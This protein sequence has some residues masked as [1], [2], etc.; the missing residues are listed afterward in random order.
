MNSRFRHEGA[1]NLLKK[2]KLLIAFFFA[3]LLVVSAS[4]YSQQTKLSMKFDEITIREV[5]RQIEE[6]SEFVFFY[7]EDY[8]NVNRKVCINVRD[9]K[10]E[11]ILNELFKG[12]ENSF[13][14]YD[15]QIV[16]LSPE[17]KEL[18]P[19]MRA[20]TK[21]EDKKNFSGT[22]KDHAGSPL[23]GVSVIVKGTTIGTIT[24]PNG[25]FQLSAPANAKVLIFSFVG[26]KSQELTI[27][28]GENFNVTL[29]EETVGIE[30]VV[31]VGYGTQK[32]KDITGSVV[33]IKSNDIIN[34]GHTSVLN[35][36]QGKL[37]GVTISS[38]SGDPGAGVNIT[39]RG[40]SSIS[41]G[42][43][44]LFI[45]DGMPYDLNP[46][47]VATSSIGDNNSSN[48]LSLINPSDIE[49]VTVLKDASATSIYGS[50]GA[51]GVIII[52]TKSGSKGKTVISIDTSLG[53]AQTT[54]KI[55]VLGGNEFIE[56]RREVDP[57]GI[58]F[59]D[60]GNPNSPRNPY[61]L[62]QHNWQDEIL[63][64]GFQQNYDLSLSGK[65]DETTYSASFG[66]LNNEAIV[67]NNDNQRYTMRLK[68]DNQK[69]KNLLIGLN[70][71]GTYSEINGATQ[72]GGGAY[73]NG[74]VQNLV[75]STP[76][77][78]YNPTF[79]P[80]NV[81]ISPASMVDQ[82]YRK[83]ATMSF[84]S[85]AYMHYAITPELKLILSG[86]GSMSSSKGTE[87]Y[88]KT[89]N[90][91]VAD[92][93]Y[94]NLG[95]ARA[96]ALNGSAQ[97]HYAK[98]FAVKHNL[99]AM[100][101]TENNLYNYEWFGVSQTN[102]LD[103]STGAFDI[104]KGSTTKST[105][106]Y[107]DMNRRISFFGRINYMYDEKHILTLNFRADGSDKFGAGNRFGYFPSA[108]Y[109]WM[110]INEK[111]MKNQSLF[112]NAKLRISYGLSG[113]DRIPSYRYLPRLENTYY[114]GVLGMAPSSQAN[115]ELKWETT[116]QSNIGIDIGIL[117]N[118][119]TLTA[120]VY[121]KQTLDML[122]PTP[123]PGRTGYYE[124]W[125]NIGRVD[126]N[127]YEVQLS[128]RN[129]DKK[130]FKWITDINISHNKNKVVDLGLV[131]FIP[132]ALSG[133]WIQDIGRVQVGR[134]IG[135]AYGYQFD[136]VYQ[137]SEFTWQDN[138]NPN[139]KDDKRNYQLKPNVVSVLGVNVKPGSFKFK[140]QNNDGTITLDKDRTPISS[141]EPKIFGGITNTFQYK[142]FELSIFFQGSYGNQIFNESKYRLEG[143]GLLTYMNVTKDF[144]YNHWTPENPTN[145][146]GD[147]ADRNATALLASS[148]YVED[149]SYIRLS[150]ISFSYNL[151]RDILSFLN[152]KTARLY[153]AG[154]NLYTWTKY[155]G[156]DPEVNSGNA[157]MTGMDR[158]SYPRARTI[159]FGLNVTF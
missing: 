4:T 71:S 144:Y 5:F 116:Y 136:G 39:I 53:M 52:E 15:R 24:D 113:N 47:E 147:Y 82:A 90:W 26:M 37:S 126:N 134:A 150:S 86:G 63:R 108:A 50:R 33:S 65:T 56:F 80:S 94:A 81:Y 97:L 32:K 96:Y 133:G 34:G 51:N 7:N 27:G 141:S 83:S 103:E 107:R 154:N 101:A 9:E 41:A 18:P 17:M 110:L 48:P 72:S 99:N 115:N 8:I 14:I 79:D 1:E 114:A 129:I 91:G 123:T 131:D 25:K 19:I 109:S 102:F 117:K 49:S 10:V 100:I 45:I 70:A 159:L 125:Q 89:T 16:I 42:T 120:D 111:F 128:S 77:E 148:Y 158:I 146:M 22:V 88:G 67:K 104:S 12:T 31:A 60:N 143:G 130:D 54:R 20:G 57:K 92:K 139:I 106:S 30:E 145:S 112:S 38:A 40:K 28:N 137:L 85:N 127:G 46:N 124:Q 105:G 21:V 152:L 74:I 87:F 138:S 75:I 58:L 43:S 93:G 157:L 62:T 59:F 95:E 55:P 149:A 132:V 2:M 3:G 140:D 151:K 13:K 68:L 29:E 66:Y 119:L 73:F 64:A 153:V 84:N 118:K 6:K 44:P 121:Q 11:S 155:S 76:V 78:L 98:I 69:T 135:E 142:N 36:I 35:G 61:A 23:P 156:Y 122:I